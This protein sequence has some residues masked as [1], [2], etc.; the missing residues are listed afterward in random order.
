MADFGFVGPSYEAASI[1]QEAQECINFYPEID[2]LKQ[3]GQRGVVA[4][5]PTPGLTEVL[6]LNNAP[7]RG[8]RTL[9]GGQWLVAVVGNAVWAIQYVNGAYTSTQVGTLTTSTG[10]VS[11]TDNIMTYGGLTAFIVDGE[12]RYYWVVG[13]ATTYTVTANVS[14]YLA[15]LSLTNVGSGYNVPTVTISAP[16]LSGGTTATATVAVNNSVTSIT[17][18]AGGSGY[19]NPTITIG[20]AW[21]AS[22]AVTV[23]Q[24]VF[25]NNNLYTYTVAGTSGST[26]PTIT[27][28]SASDGTATLMWVGYPASVSATLASGVISAITVNSFGS[29]YNSPPSLVISDST[30]TN[31]SIDLVST[32]GQ[33]EA[34]TITDAGSGYYTAPSVTIT[35][36]LN[37]AGAVATAT[38]STLTFNITATEIAV[39]EGAVLTGSP[40]VTIGAFLQTQ[41]AG[42]GGLGS[43]TVT[44]LNAGGSTTYTMPAFQK[45]PFTDGA[46]TGAVTC[47]VVDNYIVYNQGGTQAWGSTDLQADVNN[48][49]IPLVTPW[50]SNALYGNKDG[51]PDPLVGLICDHRQVFLLGEFTS[52]MWTDVGA[53][54]PG[55]ISFAFQRVPGTSLQHGVVSPFSIARF[56]E[57]FALV[58]QDT[59]G[60]A[61]IG[62]MKGY[63]FERIS[64]H[65]VEQTLMNQYVGDA[66]AY[67]YQLDGHE[68][69]V[70]TFPTVN[71]TWVYD[72][73]SQ[74]WHKWLAWDGEQ[75]QRHRSNCGALFNNVYLVGDYQN[76]MIY[77]LDNAVYTDNGATIRR[78][79]RA[80]HLVTDFQRQYFAEFQIQFQPGVGLQNG[81]GKDPQAMLRW[82]SDGGSTWS[83]EH[84][85]SM[86][87]VGQYTKRIIWRRLGW[88]RDRIFE[89]AISDP[90][91]CVIVSANLKAEGAEN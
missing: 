63:S 83:N 37:G 74:M 53:V 76:G 50:S 17:I 26:G 51:S 86:G 32:A 54:V 90:V 66:V 6:Q 81:Q 91:N 36:S 38:L 24:Q 25:Y 64:T 22:T 82:S 4:L 39:G 89:V 56:G 2:P 73:R 52:E 71:L 11:I 55:F 42:V 3:P 44:P 57:Q 31:A 88:A 70:V 41:G 84:W 34:L 61:V 87:K 79:R 18:T 48:G 8:M 30:G 75:Y 58:A 28:G 27:S 67:T 9:S 40:S 5:Y 78:L 16:S 69:Y 59:R 12:N 23:G 77:Q 13:S 15:S 65:A 19:T 14:T 29:G 45:L 43:Y 49:D 85:A 21:A 1:Y 72:L 80:P 7:V 35:D 68:F 60:Q 47:D 10:Q 33:L 20:T 46:F 62:V